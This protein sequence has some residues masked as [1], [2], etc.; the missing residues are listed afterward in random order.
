MI[1][2]ESSISVQLKLEFSYGTKYGTD[3]SNN[4]VLLRGVLKLLQIMRNR[5]ACFEIHVN[6]NGIL[7][8]I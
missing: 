6:L 8:Y 5:I 1:I 2:L 7:T 3:N 4:T